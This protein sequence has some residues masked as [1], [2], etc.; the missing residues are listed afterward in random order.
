MYNK[1]KH[2]RA[3]PANA[4]SHTSAVNELIIRMRI[5][6]MKSAIAMFDIN[7]EYLDIISAANEFM[8]F[9]ETRTYVVR[10]QK[11]KY[12]SQAISLQSAELQLTFFNTLRLYN[13]LYEFASAVHDEYLR[14]LKNYV[15]IIPKNVSEIIA[16]A[17][18]KYNEV[19][20]L[21]KDVKNIF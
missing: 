13:A 4:P 16:N 3:S 8:L 1:A 19:L 9:D 11:N 15:K 7:M 5:A 10:T 6:D 21:R 14:C 12:V 2:F 18:I 17:T 20:E